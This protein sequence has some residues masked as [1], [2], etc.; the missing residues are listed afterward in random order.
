MVGLSGGHEPTGLAVHAFFM[1]GRLPCEEPR[2]GYGYRLGASARRK[3]ELNY[4]MNRVAILAGAA[5]DAGRTLLFSDRWRNVAGWFPSTGKALVLALFAW[6][7][8]SGPA[9][10]QEPL[11]TG[12]PNVLLIVIDDLRT[13]LGCYGVEEV[14]SPNIDMHQH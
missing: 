5:H 6:G 4:K 7:F 8:A 14:H 9:P 13:E 1:S 3:M 11:K 2:P 10:A 12:K